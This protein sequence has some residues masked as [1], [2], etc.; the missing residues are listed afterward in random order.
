[1]TV[2]ELI[3]ML[4]EFPK[5]MQV[6]TPLH[7]DYTLDV[8]VAQQKLSYKP[9]SGEAYDWFRWQHPALRP[10]QELGEFLVIG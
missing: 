5:G 7:S 3:T 10:G 9:G 4:G 8:S 1:M 6:A 2:E